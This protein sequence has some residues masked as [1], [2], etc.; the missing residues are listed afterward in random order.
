M[1]IWFLAIKA[2]LINYLIY[3]KK[4]LWSRH[5]CSWTSLQRNIHMYT[6]SP[7]EDKPVSFTLLKPYASM[8]V[9]YPEKTH[10]ILI[11]RWRP[12]RANGTEHSTHVLTIASHHEKHSADSAVRLREKIR[13]KM[14]TYSTHAMREFYACISRETSKSLIRSRS[15]TRT[16]LSD[17]KNPRKYARLN[18]R[19][20]AW[21]QMTDMIILR[22]HIHLKIRGCHR[23]DFLSNCLSYSLKKVNFLL[24]VQI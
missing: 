23:E 9:A 1:Q 3:R 20:F 7:C 10:R 22:F 15:T 4:N 24:I 21:V 13:G 11:I 17:R 18:R 2:V 14:R 6:Y 5:L 19:W 16:C 12:K 8:R